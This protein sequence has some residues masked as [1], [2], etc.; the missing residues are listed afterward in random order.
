MKGIGSAFTIKPGSQK[1][2]DL[3]LGAQIEKHCVFM[4]PV[5]PQRPGELCLVTAMFLMQ[6]K[7][8]K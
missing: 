5:S 2:P 4:I 3:Y 1:E 8:S 7:L 6:L